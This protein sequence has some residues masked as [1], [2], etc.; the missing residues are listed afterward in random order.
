MSAYWIASYLWDMTLYLL[1]TIC[2]M[3]VFFM[4]GDSA[5]VFIGNA[6]ARFCTFALTLGYGFSALPFSYL[7]S[8]KFDNSSTAQISVAGLGW[9]TGFVTVIAYVTMNAVP[10]TMHVAKSLQPWF[11]L[12][13]AYNVGEGFM[14]MSTSFWER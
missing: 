7:L 11:R 8:R 2:V 1:L 14:A 6:E 10:K 5:E 9:L 4:Y 13:P 3:I 12:F